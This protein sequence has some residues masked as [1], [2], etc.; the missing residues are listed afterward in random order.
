[1]KKTLIAVVSAEKLMT[2]TLITLLSLGVNVSQAALMLKITDT[3]VVGAPIVL[4]ATDQVVGG[5]GNTT[6][7]TNAGILGLLGA[8]VSTPNF[9]LTTSS[10]SS[11]PIAPNSNTHGN[12]FLRELAISSVTGGWLT[13]EVSDNDF[14]LDGLGFNGFLNASIAGRLGTNPLNTVQVD[15]F[16][17]TSNVNFDTVGATLISSNLFS[18]GSGFSGSYGRAAINGVNQPFSITQVI[19]IHLEPNFQTLS[20]ESDLNVVPEPEM[21]LVMGLGL[22]VLIFSVR[23]GGQRSLFS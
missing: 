17:N 19:K 3:S 18:G 14:M 8:L 1:M 15:Y 21:L 20:F 7:D 12:L 23:R 6:P 13:I 10:G 9:F 5:G 11:K 22:A 16:Y 2:F 4:T